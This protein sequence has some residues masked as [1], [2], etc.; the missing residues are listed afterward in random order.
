MSPVRVG[1]VVREVGVVGH[2]AGYIVYRYN[3]E[4]LS[5]SLVYIPDTC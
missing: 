4:S 1:V 2:G 5:S 3:W